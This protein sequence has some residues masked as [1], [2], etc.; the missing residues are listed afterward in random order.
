[1]TL[2]QKTAAVIV[3]I[4]RLKNK[5]TNKRVEINNHSSNHK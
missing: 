4:N 5:I 3:L 1:M 2:N